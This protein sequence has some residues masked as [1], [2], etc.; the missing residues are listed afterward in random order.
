MPMTPDQTQA[1]T[2]TPIDLGAIFVSLEFL[3]SFASGVTTT[4]RPANNGWSFRV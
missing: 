3:C 4:V 2:A 1:P